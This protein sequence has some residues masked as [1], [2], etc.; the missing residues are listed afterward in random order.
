MLLKNPERKRGNAWFRHVRSMEAMKANQRKGLLT[1]I[2]EWI[3]NK[4]GDK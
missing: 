1:K 3:E 4:G 2:L